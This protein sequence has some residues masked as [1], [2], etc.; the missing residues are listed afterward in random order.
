VHEL[1]IAREIIAIVTAE[2]D[3]RHL[4]RVTAIHLRIGALSGVDPEALSFG[5]EA[6]T[7]DTGLEG[8]RLVIQ[9]IPVQAHCRACGQEFTVED[10]I[11][12]CP[13][14]H[15]A[16]VEVTQGEEMQIDHLVVD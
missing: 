16:D 12:L 6:A 9:Q 13:G 14:C 10:L 7:L 8:T 2:T 3:K 11:F 5:F 4:G 15:A 1:S